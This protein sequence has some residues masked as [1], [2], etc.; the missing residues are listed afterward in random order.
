MLFAQVYIRIQDIEWN[1]YRRYNQFLDL[2]QQTKKQDPI[3]ASF[4]FPPKKAMGNR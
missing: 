1:V 4:Q 2:H 3:V